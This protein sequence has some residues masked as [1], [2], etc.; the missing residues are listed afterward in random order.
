VAQVARSPVYGAVFSKDESQI[1][2]WS[3]NGTVQL[4]AVDQNQPTKIFKHEGK[5]YRAMFTHAKA[6][7]LT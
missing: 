5:I 3:E 7:S 6:A 4:R 1:L 2:T